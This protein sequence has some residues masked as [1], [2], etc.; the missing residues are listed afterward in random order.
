M[1]RNQGRLIEQLQNAQLHQRKVVQ[2][3]QADNTR[4]LGDLVDIRQERDAFR[5]EAARVRRENAELRNRLEEALT[6]CQDL[7][8]E[9]ATLVRSATL[10]SAH[11]RRPRIINPEHR[12]SVWLLRQGVL[13]KL[14]P[15]SWRRCLC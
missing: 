1:D 10:D 5:G 9:R 4:L 8:R 6:M 12:V 11:V 13:V 14:A 15:R 7:K 3:L 2:Q